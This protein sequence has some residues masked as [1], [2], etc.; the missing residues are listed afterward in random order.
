[1]HVRTTHAS[2]RASTYQHYG[3]NMRAALWFVGAIAALAPQHA[4]AQQ[5]DPAYYA[6]MRWRSI[7]PNRSGYITSVAGVPGDPTIYYIGMPE[8][9]VW[10]STNGGTTWR[11]I[12]DAASIPSI[13]AVA[14]APSAPNTVYVGTGNQSGWSFTPGKGVYKSTDAGASWMNIGLRGSTYINNI[15][16]DP[17]DANIVLVAALGARPTDPPGAERGVYRSIDGGRTWQQ[18]LGGAEGGA[19][20]LV[21]D[22]ADPSVVYAM[23][24]RAAGA[25]VTPGASSTGAYKSLDGG[26]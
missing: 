16:V 6:A 18:V 9:G 22:V 26:V 21:A 10:K 11:P 20:E 1:M 7:G 23:I 2:G 25:A 24:Q 12:F 15:V 13:G 19:S 14:V 4:S 5:V 3:D 8:G 17:R